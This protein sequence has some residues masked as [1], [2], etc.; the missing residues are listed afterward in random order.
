MRWPIDG[1]LSPSRTSVSK[2]AST[3]ASVI[4]VCRFFSSAVQTIFVVSVSSSL[5]RGLSTA[6]CLIFCLR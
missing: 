5:V 6:T 2:F 4:V 1:A 3:S